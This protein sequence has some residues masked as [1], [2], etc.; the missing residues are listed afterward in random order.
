MTTFLARMMGSGATQTRPEGGAPASLLGSARPI[1]Q[2]AFTGVAVASLGGPL[3]LATLYAPS[4]ANP[5]RIYDT[6]LTPSLFALWL[7]EL[8]TF[9]VYPRFVAKHGG[10]MLPAWVLTVLTA[11]AVTL[12]VYGLWTTIQTS[13]IGS[14]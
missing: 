14:S 7:S 8:V 10:R 5:D 1:G 2:W 13:T 6:L 4:I 3:A 12:A 9:A 11:G